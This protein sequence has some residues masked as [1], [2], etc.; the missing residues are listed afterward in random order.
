MNIQDEDQTEI[1]VI[2]PIYNVE[3]YLSRCIDSI[4]N[5]SFYNMEIILVDDGSTDGSSSLCDYYAERDGRIRVIHQ[6]NYG[7]VLAR[8]VGIQN[9]VGKYVGF[10]DADDWIEP[11]FYEILYNA[12]EKSQADFA[13]VGFIQENPEGESICRITSGFTA[14]VYQTENHKEEYTEKILLQSEITPSIWSKLFRSRIIREAYF[15][16]PDEQQL[17]EDLLCLLHCIWIAKTFQILQ[18]Q[19]Y[20]YMIRD[21]SLSHGNTDKSV[22]E[23]MLLTKY[24]I[25][26]FNQYSITDMNRME[27]IAGFFNIAAL[28]AQNS[29]SLNDW[30][31]P[32][33]DIIKGSKIIIYGAGRVGY[34][35]YIELKFRVGCN[36]VAWVDSAPEHY[37]Y[38]FQ[39]VQ[40]YSA[41]CDMEYD[42]IILA[43]KD[44]K[45][46]GEMRRAVLKSGAEEKKILWEQPHS[47]LEAF[48]HI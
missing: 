41:I 10:V 37:K 28:N 47:R 46:A 12:L 40:H 2:V 34:D 38:D 29:F 9:A 19:R 18:V 16:V 27:R 4:I 7:L 35:Y 5:Q 20:H 31:F 23:R 22:N 26:L 44:E 33:R 48:F 42:W 15:K 24:L 6:Q 32:Q 8:K 1:S 36:V 25:E 13:H 39:K 11:D 14:G 43:V 3:H 17:G 21:G 30:I 45:M